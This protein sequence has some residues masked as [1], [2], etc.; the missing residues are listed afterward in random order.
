[1]KKQ[2]KPET[3]QNTTEPSLFLREASFTG[4]L[5]EK[6]NPILTPQIS[7]QPLILQ[8]FTTLL[9]KIPQKKQ[10]QLK[11]ISTPPKTLTFIGRTPVFETY[12][13]WKT[14]PISQIQESLQPLAKERLTTFFT[15]KSTKKT[16]PNK[17]KTNPISQSFYCHLSTVL[18]SQAKGLPTL[19]GH[20]SRR[21]FNEDGKARDG[22]T[23][24]RSHL[25]IVIAIIYIF[26][27]Y[28]V[29]STRL[30]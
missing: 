1:M 18:L 13:L 16:N 14:N 17:P 7:L 11:P 28:L 19:S 8:W 10:T 5:L 22:A 21:S 29:K 4:P 2:Q 27:N 26:R 24:L 6:T 30:M 9:F 23:H 25:K 3:P 12:F 20:L 15:P